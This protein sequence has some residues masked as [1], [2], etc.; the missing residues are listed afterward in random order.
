[1]SRHRAKQGE[2]GLRGPVG[3]CSST[4][5]FIYPTRKLAR[6]G[7]AQLVNGNTL[8]VYRCEVCQGYHIGHMPK[9]VRR[10][11]LAK[12]TWLERSPKAAKAR[13]P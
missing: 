10:G 6:Q 9:Q 11:Q 8:N 13:R 1:M 5:K 12:E 7:R 2:H 4:G 3:T